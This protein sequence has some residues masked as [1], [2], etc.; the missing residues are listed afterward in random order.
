MK[1]KW[2]KKARKI[3]SNFDS[4]TGDRSPGCPVK[5][6][7]VNQLVIQAVSTYCTLELVVALRTLNEVGRGTGTVII[8][9]IKAKG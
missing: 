5:A 9:D 1:K 2:K 4:G 8:Y 3:G 6:G 7:D